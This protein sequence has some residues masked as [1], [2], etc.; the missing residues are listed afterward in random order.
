MTT[1][2]SSLRTK[3]FKHQEEGLVFLLE[4]FHGA[5]G[6]RGGLL[7]DAPG[8][9]KTL[10]AI[11]LIDRLFVLDLACRVLVVA[12]ASLTRTWMCEFETHA[13]G[14]VVEHVDGDSQ[15]TSATRTLE[16][17]AETV[18]RRVSE[19]RRRRK[20]RQRRRRRRRRTRHVEIH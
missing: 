11:A 19:T 13:P 8:M 16:R 10:M 15:I 9:G 7:G 18:V 6:L 12:P 14:L 17:L 2:T 4:R 20:R 1:T 5:G 3:L